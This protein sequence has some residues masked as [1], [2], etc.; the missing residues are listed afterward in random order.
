MLIYLLIQNLL[1]CNFPLNTCNKH[2]VLNETSKNQIT[3]RKT[4]TDGKDDKEVVRYHDYDGAQE[5]KGSVQEEKKNYK[6]LFV[7]VQFKCVRDCLIKMHGFHILVR[8]RGVFVIA[9]LIYKFMF[10]FTLQIMDFTKQQ[11]Q[12]ILRHSSPYSDPPLQE[13]QQ[14]DTEATECTDK[15][16]RDETTIRIDEGCLREQIKV[17]HRNIPS[18]VHLLM[19]RLLYPWLLLRF[20]LWDR[21]IVW[22]GIVFDVGIDCFII[23]AS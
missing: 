13:S 6:D 23:T 12:T 2:L 10:R 14:L 15:H 7:E 9:A 17:R 8:I 4:T 5:L 1:L 19:H 16:G 11:L 18:Q 20:R 21:S 22:K 3:S